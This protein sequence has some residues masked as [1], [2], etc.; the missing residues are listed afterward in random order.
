MPLTDILVATDDHRRAA[1]L[2]RVAAGYA[3]RH[4]ARLTGILYTGQPLFAPPRDHEEEAMRTFSLIAAERGVE[5]RWINGGRKGVGPD[6]LFH[7]ARSTGLVMISQPPGGGAAGRAPRPA[8]AA[9]PQCRPAG[10]HRS[11]RRDLLHLRRTGDRGLE[12]RPRIGQGTPRRPPDPQAGA[13]GQASGD[14]GFRRG[15]HRPGLGSTPS[16][17]FW[18]GAA[19]MP[20]R[21]SCLPRTSPWPTS[22]STG[23]RKRGATSSS[24]GPSATHPAAAPSWAGSPGISSST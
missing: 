9:D 19:S 15:R 6:V 18:S 1:P 11:L 20:A 16:T 5:S 17:P 12:R 7:H 24:W 22:S 2:F 3:S 13:K 4:G 10:P 8:G 14:G 23:R 21:R